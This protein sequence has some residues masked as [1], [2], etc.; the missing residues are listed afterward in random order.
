MKIVENVCQMIPVTELMVH[1]YM[2][3]KV[4]IVLHYAR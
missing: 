4:N 1:V 2:A 3:V